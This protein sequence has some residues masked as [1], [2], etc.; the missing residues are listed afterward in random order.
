MARTPLWQPVALSENFGD[1]APIAVVQ[2]DD[3]GTVSQNTRT[4]TGILNTTTGLTTVQA[5][6]GAVDTNRAQYVAL[7]W[8]DGTAPLLYLG[9]GTEEAG[10]GSMVTPANTPTVRTGNTAGTVAADRVRLSLSRAGLGNIPLG[11]IDE[12]RLTAFAMTQGRL[13]TQEVAARDPQLFYGVSVPKAATDP[14]EPPV[15]MPDEAGITAA[16]SQIDI[17]VLANDTDP[18]GHARTLVSVQAPDVGSTQ[19]VGGQARWIKPASG[20]G[21]GSRANFTYV[22]SA[23]AKQV[24][25][26]VC[27][28]HVSG[29]GAPTVGVLGAGPQSGVK[30]YSGGWFNLNI[31]SFEIDRGTGGIAGRRNADCATQSKTSISC[32]NWANWAGCVD[33]AAFNAQWDRTPQQWRDSNAS[34]NINDGRLSA[35]GV[36]TF[37][38]STGTGDTFSGTNT[39][40]RHNGFAGFLGNVWSGPQAT[41]FRTTNR[42]THVGWYRTIPVSHSNA[43][44]A[45]PQTWD[46]AAAGQ[47]DRYYFMMGRKY[48]FLDWKYGY[49]TSRKLTVD[50]MYENLF[51]QYTDFPG[52]AWQNWRIA[53]LRFAKALRAGYAFQ[54]GA[55]CPY[56][57]CWRPPQQSSVSGATHEQLVPNQAQGTSIT[58]TSY[59]STPILPAGA[60]GR[61]LDIIGLSLHDNLPGG[62]AN[63]L[64][65]D[66]QNITNQGTNTWALHLDGVSNAWGLRTM[67]EA[68]RA[69]GVWACF[70]EWGPFKN[71][72]SSSSQGF[73]R[74]NPS[75]AP[76]GYCR[77]L[78]QTWS[79][80][81]DVMAYECN[82]HSGDSLLWNQWVGRT[83]PFIGGTPVTAPRVEP[84]PVYKQLWFG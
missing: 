8:K 12:V 52:T 64:F 37:G 46:E 58:A 38:L 66:E 14:D 47:F 22:M 67:L 27:V 55:A 82:F 48:A 77:L 4:L 10:F 31:E 65:P 20:W 5:A 44:N 78:Y 71:I 76:A 74:N 36:P 43:A 1:A 63:V 45:R 18:D 57:F 15:A 81:L 83:D 9:K 33:E 41:Y 61:Q 2:I 54:A 35:A 70:P 40:F 7:V 80:Y 56:W 73:V 51:T 19:L 84:G 13:R 24:R 59:R 49:G 79:Q 16:Q 60:I 69:Q 6:M 42:L 34:V 23:N 26:H 11:L 28:R 30:W 32:P 50:L 29:G 3:D 21:P 72:H 53:W 75:K 25:G 17:N 68:C 39:S 62:F